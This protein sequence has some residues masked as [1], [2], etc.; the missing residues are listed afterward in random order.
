MHWSSSI[1]R[2]VL[3]FLT[4]GLFAQFGFAH[5]SA[6]E[7]DE[8]ALSAAEI[9][10]RMARSYANCKTYQDSGCVTTAFIK[11]DGERIDNKPF[12]TAFIRPTRF[13]FE[14]KS[15]FDGTNWHRLI[16]WADGPDVRT[17]WHIR[18]E[19]KQQPSLHLGLAGATGVSG[20]SAHTIPAL[21]MPESIGGRRLTDLTELKRLEDAQLGGVECFRIQGAINVHP[22]DLERQRR[23]VMKVTGKDLGTSDRG[24]KTLW[25]DKSRFLLLQIEEQ[26]QFDSFRTESMT[27]YEPLMDMPIADNQLQFDPPISERRN[28]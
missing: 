17:W 13:R 20:A 12:S 15:S 6:S 19:V 1:T 27:T 22:A 21:L 3:L 25:I 18:P 8:E 26:T 2:R 5:T 16:V 4:G 7:A 28:Q 24:P 23:E 11:A 10:E 9:L 14:F